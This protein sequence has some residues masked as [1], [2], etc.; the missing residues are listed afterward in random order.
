MKT[1]P[2][3]AV[4]LI[5]SLGVNLIQCHAQG[6]S[7]TFQGRLN[8]NGTPANGTYDVIFA[9]YGSA[10]GTNDGL[11]NQTNATVVLSNGL[12]TV[13]LN[14]GPGIFNG[15][16]RW[17]DI[18]V[19]TNGAAAFT[20]LSPRQKLMA[21]PYAI[22]AG[23]FVSGSLAGTFTNAVSFNHSAN[24]FLGIFTGNGTGL[25][26]V[27]AVTLGGLSSG[28]FWQ[29]SGTAG[30]TAG[31]NFLGTTDNQPLE[32][33][34]NGSRAL[35]LEPTPTDAT[36]VEIVNVVGGSRANVVTPGVYGATIA[37][38][39]ASNWF[40]SAF[41]HLLDADFGSIGGGA[42]NIIQYWARYSTIGGGLYNT[43]QTNSSLSTIGGGWANT[44]GPN[45]GWSTIGGGS[46]NAI[47]TNASSSTIGG[48]YN[49]KVQTSGATIAG[50]SHNAIQTNAD[51]ST[52]GGGAYNRIEDSAS[53]STIDGGL[54]NAI[55]T[56]APFSTIGGGAFNTIQSN[57]FRSTIGGGYL[58]TVFG[59][60]GT[61]PGGDQN[62]AGENSFAAGHRAKANHLASFVWADSQEAD[63]TST[64]NNQF[65]IRA[66]GGVRL[67]TDTSLFFDPHTRQMLNL[68]GATYGIGVQSLT[69]YF[70]TDNADAGT[71][72][73]WF[74]GGVHDDGQNNPG[75]GGVELM[76]LTSAGLTVNGT[77][78]STSDRNAKE[79]FRKVDREEILAK[80]AALPLSRWNYKED[81]ASEH[82]GPMAQDFHATFGIGPDNKHIATVDADGVA[83]AAIQGLNAKVE[84]EM[85]NAKRRIESL[86][87]ENSELKTRLQKLEHVLTERF[88]P[89][90]K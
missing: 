80:V 79:N 42:A 52:V 72:F 17:L 39:G 26:N 38:G 60:Y 36:H 86:E 25:T 37:G 71:G 43:I 53:G 66:H 5:L 78:V 85:R 22:T 88:Q 90:A 58:N 6:T 56:N 10:T 34:V 28:S 29:T 61:V 44:I 12:F 48:G 64:I 1:T 9:V 70:R 20:S 2:L 13:A 50:G 49:N 3:F 74:K 59:H 45:A 62:V 68:W 76:R 8:A 83:L 7:F 89:A 21:T 57:A 67:N 81:T 16:E 55:Q 19:R 15:D 63:F 11:A 41:G 87:Q 65:N 33:K 35:R 77:F 14:F 30:T 32:L 40:F 51:S 69:M 23:N 75:A 4:M 31:T 47:Q 73:S 84:T 18:S 24:S 54:A 27:N 82:I 46:D